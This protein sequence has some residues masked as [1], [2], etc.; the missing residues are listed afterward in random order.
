MK[1][2]QV[3]A[4]R[5]KRGLHRVNG[6]EPQVVGLTPQTPDIRKT[7]TMKT[8][9]LRQP[10]PV[11]PQKS[12][13][14]PRP[15]PVPPVAPAGHCGRMETMTKGP[16]LFIGLDTVKPQMFQKTEQG[17]GGEGTMGHCQLTRFSHECLHLGFVGVS[18]GILTLPTPADKLSQCGAFGAEGIIRVAGLFQISEERI[19]LRCDE[20]TFWR[21]I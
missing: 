20:V 21:R 15:K 8:Y 10:K 5:S 18:A 2:K 17:R 3:S 7:D 11:E 4:L 9:I 6:A 13:R 12:S 19:N 16:V 1:V 14:T